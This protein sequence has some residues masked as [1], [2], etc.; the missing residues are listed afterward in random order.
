MFLFG[1]RYDAAEQYHAQAHAL[2]FKTAFKQGDNDNGLT[3]ADISDSDLARYYSV[4]YQ[5]ILESFHGHGSEEHDES[6]R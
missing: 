5:K 4:I 2:D 6:E 1:I 3:M